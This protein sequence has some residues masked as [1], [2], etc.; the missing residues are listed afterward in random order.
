[1]EAGSEPLKFYNLYTLTPL[2]DLVAEFVGPGSLLNTEGHRAN[3]IYLE[4]FNHA[5]VDISSRRLVEQAIIMTFQYC[6][7]TCGDMTGVS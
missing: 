5:A 4:P 1:M 2:W 7:D 6:Q 3:Y